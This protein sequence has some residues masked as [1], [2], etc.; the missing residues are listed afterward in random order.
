MSINWLF[1]T[2]M[3][4]FSFGLWGFFSRVA[5]NYISPLQMIIYQTVGIIFVTLFM[6]K[7]FAA[8]TTF[9]VVGSVFAIL[10]GIAFTVGSILFFVAT[11]QQGKISV[12]ITLTA[13]YPLVTIILA[14]IFLREAITFQQ[15]FGMLL[16][17]GAMFLLSTSS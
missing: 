13:L 8:T 15:W 5:L 6:L 2:I 3:C 12:V 17:V 14:F 11:D 16:A 1:A 4:L 10:T 9:S 7:T